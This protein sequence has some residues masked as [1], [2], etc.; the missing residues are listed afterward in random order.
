MAVGP[1]HGEHTKSLVIS[2]GGMIFEPGQQLNGF[3]AVAFEHGI[4]DDEDGVRS[5][6]VS[7]LTFCTVA[8]LSDV[9]KRR[10]AKP[11]W[12]RKR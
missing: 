5:A 9:R 1:S 11:A 7:T 4:V 12:L 10:Q 3:A 8:T 6:D 2:A